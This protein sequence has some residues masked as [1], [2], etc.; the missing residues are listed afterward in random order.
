[1]FV[2]GGVAT[3]FYLKYRDLIANMVGHT[4]VDLVL[5]VGL[6]LVSGG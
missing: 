2:V 5:N 3:L 1:M 4:V 6:P